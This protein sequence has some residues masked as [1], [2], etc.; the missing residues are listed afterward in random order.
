MF[1]HDPYAELANLKPVDSFPVVSADFT[2]DGD[3][4][5]AHYAKGSGGRDLSPQLSWS[6]FPSA[7]KSFAVTC[8]DPDAP[9]GTGWWHWA[10]FNLPVSVTSLDS[11]AGAP[12]SGLLPRGAITLPNE[13]RLAAFGGAA[14]PPGTGV[15]RYIFVV[16]ALDV[17][18]L[19]L[20]AQSTPAVLGINLFFHGLGRGILTARGEHGAA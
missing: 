4:P 20:D 11:G 3:L 6:G 19:S 9:T 17:A 12:H 16:H 15:H 2:D 13:S 7:T 1:N 10:V 14:P 5:L 8:L 18:S